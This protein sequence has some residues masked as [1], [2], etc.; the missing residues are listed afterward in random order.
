VFLTTNALAVPSNNTRAIAYHTKETEDSM[1]GNLPP[2][3][4]ICGAIV[5]LLGTTCMAQEGRVSER[6]KIQSLSGGVPS[7][8]TGLAA[9]ALSD[10][11][12]GDPR[13]YYYHPK[14]AL[15]LGLGFDPADVAD[16]K[17]PCIVRDHVP[18][19]PGSPKTDLAMTYVRTWDQLNLSM[20]VDTKTEASVL[21]FKGNAS[22]SIDTS[23][24]FTTNSITVVMTASSDFGRW[25]LGPKAVLTEEAKAL[26]ADGKAFAR[27]CGTR[28]VA[29]ERRGA[30][31]SAVITLHS[32]QTEFKASFDAEFA[33]S[34]GWGRVSA[35]AQTKLHGAISSAAN[36]D[37]LSVQVGATGGAGLGGLKGTIEKLAAVE[38]EPSKKILE[39]VDASLTGFTKEN[40]SPTEYV[41][42]SMERYGWDPSTIDPWTDFKERKLR[43]LGRAYREAGIELDYLTAIENGTS[44]LNKL[45]GNTP[46]GKKW[47]QDKIQLKPDLMS[48]IQKIAVAHKKCKENVDLQYCEVP[49]GQVLVL[50]PDEKH[51]LE[52][53]KASFYVVGQDSSNNKID[54]TEVQVGAIINAKRGHRLSVA[55]A[56]APKTAQIFIGLNIDGNFLASERQIFQYSD[57][58]SVGSDE[59]KT[60]G[61]PWAE[62]PTETM[63]L[64]YYETALYTFLG[65][66]NG[67]FEGS[68]LIQV[69]DEMGRVFRITLCRARWKANGKNVISIETDIYN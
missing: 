32:V 58:R 19:D 8:F 26:L 1:M 13:Y 7:I 48:H 33:N 47:L 17:R 50:L 6:P 49:P 36:Q 59:G 52:P 29:I 37:R 2:L 35:S 56:F 46:L 23:S 44:A 10:V 67:S 18:L 9:G 12:E 27:I 64:Q 11:V 40:A 61:Y 5:V 25:G 63:K 14:T 22:Y 51:W 21:A 68:E 28:Y 4:L 41:V 65:Q 60:G 3:G 30:S 38:K 15:A 55:R 62:E 43:A 69:R 66:H 34:G 24:M 45:F 31:V 42:Q 16:P 54:F 53:P 39:A 57:G 20:N